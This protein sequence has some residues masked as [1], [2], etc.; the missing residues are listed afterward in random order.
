MSRSSARV[1]AIGDLLALVVFV[2]LGRIVHAGSGP[3]DWL[4]NAPRIAAPFLLGWVIAAPV[5][6][7]Y[8]RANAPWTGRFL[9]N[10]AFTLIAADLIAFA[11]RGYLFSDSV[12]VPFVLTAFAFTA[13]LVLGWRLVFARILAPRTA[14]DSL[15]QEA[16]RQ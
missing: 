4:A 16:V 10:S 9:L 3:I 6:S 15:S 11:V 5:F 12:T 14:R 13:L 7:A 2:I 8:A 1:L